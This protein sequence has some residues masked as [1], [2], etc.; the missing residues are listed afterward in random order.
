MT[1]SK[2]TPRSVCV[3]GSKKISV[4][5][6][7]SAAAL[8][9]VGPGHVEEVL[10]LQQHAG[11]G[12]V[13]VQEALQV[14]EGVGR[15]QRLHA[16]VGQRHAVAPGQVKMSSGSSEPSMWMCSSA[17]GMRRSSAGSRSRGSRARSA[18]TSGGMGAGERGSEAVVMVTVSRGIDAAAARRE[19]AWARGVRDWG[20]RPLA[21]P[22]RPAPPGCRSGTRAGT[23]PRSPRRCRQ[24]SPAE[25][26]TRAS[27][28][29]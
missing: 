27:P 29:N 22:F 20:D 17:L 19:R 21:D 23:A 16:G 9:E 7:L 24:P 14:C 26:G 15:A 8:L 25:T 6:T 5:T 28:Q 18:A 3:C 13:D 2:G 12:V 4:C 11:A 1:V 10:L